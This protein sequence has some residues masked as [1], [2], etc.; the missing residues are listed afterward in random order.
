MCYLFAEFRENRLSSFCVIL[1]ANKQTN[2]QTNNLLGGCIITVAPV[3]S[4]I[5]AWAAPRQKQ[6]LMTFVDC[7]P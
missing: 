4:A 7:T 2:K 5:G 3:L 6:K 1:P